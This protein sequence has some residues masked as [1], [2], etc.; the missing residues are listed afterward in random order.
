MISSLFLLIL[1]EVLWLRSSYERAFQDFRRDANI[2]FRT[3]VMDMRDSLLSKNIEVISSDTTQQRI[4]NIFTIETDS[5]ELHRIRD[6]VVTRARIHSQTSQI[7]VFVRQGDS[8][9]A[10][11]LRPLAS[12][13]LTHDLRGGK[14]DSKRFVVR[15][16]AD[17]LNRDSLRIQFKKILTT[18]GIHTP[19]FIQYIQDIEHAEPG[20]PGMPRAMAWKRISSS[21]LEDEGVT[22]TDTLRTEPI[23]FNPLHSYT[24]SFTGMRASLIQKI[25]PQILFSLFLTLMITGAFILMYRNL[26]AQEK[27]MALKNDFISNMT[28]ELKT[29]VATVSVALE[30]LK[31]F[32][33]MNDQKLSEE[34]LEI[35]QRELS[36]LNG[37][38]EKILEASVFESKGIVFTPGKT[39]IN[40]LLNEVLLANKAVFDKRH[41]QVSVTR[42]GGP[43][44]LSGSAAYLSSVIHNLVDNA[45]KYSPDKPVIDIQLTADQK[46]I[47][48]I[49]EDHGIGIPAEYQKKI[50][51]K[52]FRVPTGDVHNTK[53]YG[54]GL[55]HVASIVKSHGGTIDVSG[56][57][58][59]GSK[60]KVTIPKQNHGEN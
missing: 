56:E 33:A 50:F 59:K 25:T 19:F 4:N 22:N 44:T 8:V 18:A 1:F 34:Y 11:V 43:F 47:T 17:S 51:E 52:F 38:T 6:T 46:A 35:A 37:M 2:L 39:D 60:F 23:K 16:T 41:A 36:R 57:P 10:D 48:L 54:L 32:R 40:E 7:Q 27:L 21:P 14:G 24:A 13:I 30:A 20:L 28:H 58:G 3:T 9:N 26:R 15:L 53:G 12:K 5:V 42:Q 55:S 31:N 45:L 29:P 49:I